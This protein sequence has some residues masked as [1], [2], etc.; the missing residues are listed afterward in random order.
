MHRRFNNSILSDNSSLKSIKVLLRS[1]STALPGTCEKADDR[2][3]AG[4][5]GTG[6]STDEE[7]PAIKAMTDDDISAGGDGKAVNGD[8]PDSRGTEEGTSGLMGEIR[9]I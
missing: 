7:T 5:A 8:K 3:N 9:S 2:D 6:G 4:R 1:F